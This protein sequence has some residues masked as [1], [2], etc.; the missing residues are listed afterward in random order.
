KPS[1]PSNSDENSETYPKLPSPVIAR[2]YHALN[3]SN[4]TSPQIASL[5]LK[6]TKST[7]SLTN[8]PL[9]I[10]DE[11]ET[12]LEDHVI[13][14]QPSDDGHKAITLNGITGFIL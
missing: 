3:G 6:P 10:F 11:E 9:Q 7:D 12:L 8:H 5:R 4:I 13:V 1:T 14:S 2:S